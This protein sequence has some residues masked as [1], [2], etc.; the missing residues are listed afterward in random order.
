M[1]QR[2]LTQ[3]LLATNALSVSV[4]S[5]EAIGW[6]WVTEVLLFISLKVEI[7][8]QVS[9][10]DRDLLQAHAPTVLLPAEPPELCC[11]G[12]SAPE[13]DL[14]LAQLRASFASLDDSVLPGSSFPLIRED[15]KM[16]Q[17]LLQH[18]AGSLSIQ[19]EFL[20][21]NTLLA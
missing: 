15:F 6:P 1:G 7:A 21:E 8:G 2:P 14:A 19:I 18:V 4:A 12:L 11:L 10:G 3:R 9:G 20:Q 17:D 5:M 13:Q 16:Y